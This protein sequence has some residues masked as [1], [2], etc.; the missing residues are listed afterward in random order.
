[1]TLIQISDG[2]DWI[3][4]QFDGNGPQNGMRR[5]CHRDDKKTIRDNHICQKRVGVI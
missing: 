4:F 2:R 5:K 3:V 1:M